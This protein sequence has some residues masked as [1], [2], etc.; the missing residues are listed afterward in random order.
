MLRLQRGVPYVSL[1]HM[2]AKKRKI[3]DGDRIRIWND[4]GEFYAQ[5]KV[6][7][8]V[9]PGTIVMDHAWEPHQFKN[10]KGMDAPVAGLLSPFELAGGWGHLKFGAE[11]DGNQM[12][13]ESS[14][15]VE[16]A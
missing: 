11:W 9:C 14:V 16:K 10:K 1:S 4:I 8:N 5:A 2:D 7:P 15:Q 3:K 13:Y 6:S 12:A